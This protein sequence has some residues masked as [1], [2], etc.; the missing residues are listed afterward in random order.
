MID[1]LVTL[2]LMLVALVAIGL[3]ATHLDDPELQI[4]PNGVLT[5]V[6]YTIVLVLWAFMIGRLLISSRRARRS[7]KRRLARMERRQREWEEHDD[8]ASQW[9]L[10]LRE[11][12]GID[13]IKD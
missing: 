10:D 9:K 2:L 4:E 6:I 7:R 11:K 1:G 5:A 13:L 12:R 8:R 3:I